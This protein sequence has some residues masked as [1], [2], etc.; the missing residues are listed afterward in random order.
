MPIKIWAS[1][2]SDGCATG[3]WLHKNPVSHPSLP[4]AEYIRADI[5]EAEI[6]KQ[7][8]FNEHLTD[9]VKEYTKHF[10]ENKKLRE[11]VLDLANALRLARD[12]NMGACEGCDNAR[13]AALDKYADIIKECGE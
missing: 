13:N 6:K 1:P 3:F 10:K 8:R 11:A 7:V 5:H 9:L 2:H 4:D 12:C